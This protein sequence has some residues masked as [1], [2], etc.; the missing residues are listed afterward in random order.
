MLRSPRALRRDLAHSNCDSF[1]SSFMTGA[2]ETFLPAYALATGASVAAV[3]LLA[4]LPVLIGSTI[5]LGA[6]KFL[7][8][9][10][11][12]RKFVATLAILQAL[13]FIPFAYCA[14]IGYRVPTMAFVFMA[15]LYWACS[16]SGGAA[17]Q[18][19]MTKIVPERLRCRYF[20]RRNHIGQIGLLVGLVSGGVLLEVAKRGDWELKAF[21]GLFLFSA[22][23]RF[24][25]SFFIGRQTAHPYLEPVAAP[26]PL[27]T[28]ARRLVSGEGGSFF[29]YLFLFA[30]A[31][32]VSSPYFN[33][34]VLK[35]LQFSYDQ[36]MWLTAVVL[37][38]KIFT[39]SQLTKNSSG[40]DPYKIMYYGLIGAAL[41]PASWL[42]SHNFYY[43]IVM[44]IAS[45]ACW[46][47]Y[48]LGLVLVLLRIVRDSERTR[49]LSVYNFVSSSMVLIGTLIGGAV[50]TFIGDDL[51]TY[52]LVFG[53]STVLRLGCLILF[54]NSLVRI[55]GTIPY[56]GARLIMLVRNDLPLRAKALVFDAPV[57]LTRSTFRRKPPGAA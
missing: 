19:W 35:R 41:T 45:G 36:Y 34:Y 17:W 2:G 6:P 39:F 12:Y 14:M 16:L 13:S 11:C 42:V 52:F 8:R 37:V 54:E 30:I 24:S 46:A 40:L 33:P 32:S 23:A 21:G 1:L 10:G 43:L 22:V 44:Q 7:S 15:S 57:R 5:Q 53:L 47:A 28:I 3:G 27:T 29:T 31:T 49:V 9:V 51:K 18:S 20:A 25:S 4:A 56:R 48:E 38:A 26:V 55:K 50:L